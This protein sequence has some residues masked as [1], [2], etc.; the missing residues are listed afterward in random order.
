M[1]NTNGI[2]SEDELTFFKKI[3]LGIKKF[4]NSDE[5]HDV[6]IALFISLGL[7]AAA[8]IVIA[9][10]NACI[11]GLE[12]GASIV[13]DINILLISTTA[14][15]LGLYVTAFIFLNDSLK[16]RSKEDSKIKE[17]VDKILMRY[18]NDMIWV[19]VFTI[20]SI[21]L[22]V[23]LNIVLGAPQPDNNIENIRLSLNSW[24]WYLFIAVTVYS[25]FII[26]WIILESRNI[27]NSD[28]LIK[29]QS[30]DNL[31][32]HKR[33]LLD[34][35]NNILNEKVETSEEF[36][37]EDNSGLKI[38]QKFGKKKF[39]FQQ[40]Y[41]SV[42]DSG[43][44]KYKDGKW[45]YPGVSNEQEYII[46]LGKI[47]RLIENIVSRICDNNIDKSIMNN[48]LIFESMRSGFLWLYAHEGKNNVLDVRDANRFLDH[49]KYQIITNKR[50][51]DK[52]FDNN[53]VEE[54]FR[55]AR[56]AFY[57]LDYGKG[58]KA[59]TVYLD[60]QD[61]EQQVK[62]STDGN[63]LEYITAYKA[64]MRTI[65]DQ[66]FTGYEHLIGYRDAL[67]RNNDLK[68][69]T[70]NIFKRKSKKKV[71]GE[72]AEAVQDGNNTE[73][74]T[75]LQGSRNRPISE[76][77]H[78]I[79]IFSEIMKRVLID[80]FTSFV[81]I[82]DLNLGNSTLTKGWFNYSELTKSNF[83]HTSFKFA[84][85]ESAIFRGCDLSTCSFILADA[86]D[87][88]F[89]GS[90]FSYSDLT[91]MD[92]SDSILNNTQ[93]N[94]VLLRDERLDHY[95]GYEYLFT[96]NKVKKPEQLN[97]ENEPAQP[98]NAV[99]EREMQMMRQQLRE[100]EIINHV[101]SL[102]AKDWYDPKEE[103]DGFKKLKEAFD[104]SRKGIYPT[105]LSS[106]GYVDD[107]K[108][109][110]VADTIVYSKDSL[111][112][113]AHE[114]LCTDIL[115]FFFEY[116]V[117]N[118][119]SKET[120]EAVCEARKDEKAELKMLREAMYGKVYFGVAN[121]EAASVNNVSMK[122]IDFS[123]VNISI[124]S[125][126]DSDLSG[127]DMYY[128]KARKA[129]FYRTNL[130]NVDAYRTEFEESNF[131]SASM[132]DTVL[133]DC[134]LNGCNFDR[135]ILL[136]AKLINSL[137]DDKNN[138]PRPYLSRFIYKLSGVHSG[139][140]ET[141][142]FVSDS[143][144][145]EVDKNKVQ[146]RH[147]EE[148]NDEHSCV[149]SDFTEAL[150][151]HI[152]IMN[153][154]MVRSIFDKI[155]AKDAFIYNALMRW[156]VFKDS[157]LSNS[158]CYGTSFH[159]SSFDGAKFSRAKLIACEFSNASLRNTNMISVLLEKVIFDE[160]NLSYCNFSGATIENCS[161]RKCNFQKVILS[162]TVFKNVI[163]SQIDFQSVIGLDEAIFI[164]CAFEMK[165]KGNVELGDELELK[166]NSQNVYLRRV[167]ADNGNL[168]GGLARYSSD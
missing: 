33:C 98:Q 152:V 160:A 92:L 136:R 158:I 49:L 99:E 55:R 144:V 142:E 48:E 13:R 126:A 113:R 9:I 151:D 53:E 95:G 124:A 141:I 88:D 63:K 70:V 107:E 16:T 78:K 8:L 105:I 135:A 28:S 45:V 150:A 165:D 7:L 134:N 117:K 164:D 15:L 132:I 10:L 148:L 66:F 84:R 145:I 14:T 46:Q 161:F 123:H 100:G 35:F 122:N 19:A 56:E 62:K 40:A 89:T 79:L 68:D 120:L 11:P 43:I 83:T 22:E 37:F 157:D 74:T 114:I 106:D 39:S 2:K 104:G 133:V 128:T 52:P 108:A 90:N 65:I 159:Q 73:D 118:K 51:K 76:D 27:T 41:K 5:C 26:S 71:K 80:R 112:D 20:I 77:Q 82:D 109:I 146:M 38:L 93:M 163:F 166:N 60:G 102:F 115:K 75:L 140:D 18:R 17:A 69:D 111:L 57:S 34:Q 101:V 168:V 85:L 94:S 47:V 1:R 97:C 24:I 25:I 155:S 147:I 167:E 131:S 29:K 61:G 153:V 103:Q 72:S 149:G 121:L 12:I 81:K 23:L 30:T 143:E 50:F 3:R 110:S 156:C 64:N 59:G 137:T 96:K 154:N 21:V 86:S 139:L 44:I 119:L 116:R 127:T 58:D 138:L 36:D 125:F 129:R 6:R 4:F 87:T 67:V 54:T 32:L 42:K 91:G 162:G 31:E 130:N